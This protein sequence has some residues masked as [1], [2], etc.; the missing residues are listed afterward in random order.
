MDSIQAMFDLVDLLEE[1][2][3]QATDEKYDIADDKC[4]MELSFAGSQ[5]FP[6]LNFPTL[7]PQTEEPKEHK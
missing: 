6:T 7:N 5:T 4:S 1:H 2:I 3:Y